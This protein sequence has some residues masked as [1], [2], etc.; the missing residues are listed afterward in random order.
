[1]GKHTLT[2]RDLLN[3]LEFTNSALAVDD[4]DRFI[5]LLNGIKTF[6]PYEYAICALGNV[7]KNSSYQINDMINLSYPS[8]W[9]NIYLNR[10]FVAVDP[11]IHTHFTEFKP[12]IFT[13]TYK[14]TSDIHKDFF[15]ISHDFGLSDGVAFGL[16]D[17]KYNTVSLFSF[18]SLEE[19]PSQR[20]L[21][22]LEILVPHLHQLYVRL[23]NENKSDN[24][25]EVIH[26]ISLRE[27]E[28][29]KWLQE[30]KT[31]WETSMILN[32]SERTV[33]FHVS[34]LIKKLNAVNRGHVVAK[35]M[36]IR[37]L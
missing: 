3:L 12:Q 16:Y 34:N 4:K 36:E 27:K 24:T 25:D 28:V 13:E 5:S 18:A 35:A 15:Y 22:Y 14:R 23:S 37:I 7:D 19:K 30:G 1:M 6:I 10:G 31:N 17:N 33:K 8:E 32:I 21:H 9:M 29:L 11:I 2:K 20:H 26:N